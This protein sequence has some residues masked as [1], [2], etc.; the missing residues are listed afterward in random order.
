MG[1][2][3]TG[4]ATGQFLAVSL[5]RSS[6]RVANPAAG[7]RQ[8]P[9]MT[10][11]LK[12]RDLQAQDVPTLRFGQIPPA[13]ETNGRPSANY[14][15]AW[16]S[17][18]RFAV[19]FDPEH[20]ASGT[21]D[22]R[23]PRA[24]LDQ[25]R[26]TFS[27]CGSLDG[28]PISH[29]RSALRALFER[30]EYQEDLSLAPRDAALADCLLDAIYHDVSGGMRRPVARLE[31]PEAEIGPWVPLLGSGQHRAW[32]KSALDRADLYDKAAGTL[33]RESGADVRVV[34]LYLYPP[35]YFPLE[36]PP[37]WCGHVLTLLLEPG[38]KSPR[39][40]LEGQ[41][42]RLFRALRSGLGDRASDWGPH[43]LLGGELR[44]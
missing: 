25:A 9:P 6:G 31:S 26:R 44:S 3:P 12:N 18:W 36:A 11:M 21:A 27:R 28:E 2:S 4:C 17:L 8:D 35:Q 33:L 42:K 16:D 37:P 39:S 30:V 5:M 23:P 15:R 20:Y 34:G 7:I 22:S 10:K 29:L 19:T 32:Y 14:A 24:Y 41:Y 13:P 43:D 38:P 1:T 40:S